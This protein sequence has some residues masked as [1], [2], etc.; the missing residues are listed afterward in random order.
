MLIR[1]ERPQDDQMI[2]G[3]HFL[4]FGQRED[5]ARM[6]ANVRATDGYNPELSLVAEETGQILGHALFSKAV[7]KN[8][9]NQTEVIV[10]APIGVHPDHQKTGIGRL[11]IEEG[12]RKVR[13]LDYALVLLIGHPSYYPKFGFEPARPH[14]LELTQFK[15]PDE[16]FMVCEVK[17][18]A[19]KR[20]KGELIFPPAF[21]K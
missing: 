7:I 10:L 16:V 17:P 21:F 8:D 14:G 4:A 18:G 15:V 20:S 9:K 3:L 19:L 2:A 1:S 13:E 11:L 6:V 12:L 5:E